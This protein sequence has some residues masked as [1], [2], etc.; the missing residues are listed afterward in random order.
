VINVL[1]AIDAAPRRLKMKNF[2]IDAKNDITVHGSAKEAEAFPNSERFGDEAALA[3]L[4]A[5]WPSARLV[6][7][8][9]SLPG[10]T[11]VR[12]FKDRAT[13]ASRIWKAIQNLGEVRPATEEPTPIRETVQATELPETAPVSDPL[14][15]EELARKERDLSLISPHHLVD[16]YRRAHE[17]CRMDGDHLPKAS[18]VQEMV[19]AWKL[20]WKRRK[21]RDP[22]RG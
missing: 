17:A 22:G 2:T 7:I 16:A 5:E 13:A 8:W 21:R 9:N 11:Q 15:R 10:E 3:K 12:K 6:E 18:A 4:A 20:M 1:I 19:A 14:T